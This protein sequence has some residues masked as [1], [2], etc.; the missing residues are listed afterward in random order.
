MI[1]FR[2]H[3]DRLLAIMD[4]YIVSYKLR[5]DYFEAMKSPV[6]THP[7]VKNSRAKARI[8]KENIQ[9]TDQFQG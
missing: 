1:G 6:A 7:N 3:G 9:N 4:K 8:E 5:L 2:V